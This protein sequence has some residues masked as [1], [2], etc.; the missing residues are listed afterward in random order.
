MICSKLHHESS[1]HAA[2]EVQ[3]RVLAEQIEAPQDEEIA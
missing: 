3:G 2:L 1:F